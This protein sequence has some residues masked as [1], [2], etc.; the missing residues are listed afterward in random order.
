M[1]HD[2]NNEIS[3][4]MEEARS[5][6]KPISLSSLINKI[7]KAKINI[8]KIKWQ[9]KVKFRLSACTLVGLG[10]VGFYGGAHIFANLNKYES[11]ARKEQQRRYRQDVENQWK[12]SFYY[13][14]VLEELN[15]TC[16]E[17]APLLLQ[18]NDVYCQTSIPENNQTYY[19]NC[20][21]SNASHILESSCNQTFGSLTT[22]ESCA[23]TFDREFSGPFNDVFQIDCH[24]PSGA[25]IGGSFAAFLI[26]LL[27][28]FGCCVGAFS[29]W[30]LYSRK[31]PIDDLAPDTK[32]LLEEIQKDSHLIEF[33]T[34]LKKSTANEV[35]S[36]L[37]SLKTKVVEKNERNLRLM[38]FLAKFYE[39]ESNTGKQVK[40]TSI[41]PTDIVHLICYFAELTEISPNGYS[42]PLA[43]NKD[44]NLKSEMHSPDA[45]SSSNAYFV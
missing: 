23:T 6:N 39:R 22:F 21:S 33:E 35:I 29:T 32:D 4:P 31:D 5:D 18:I 1:Q 26:L 44:G 42:T 45:E 3:I 25:V 28:A 30:P 16:Q 11:R 2:E 43:S 9:K 12:T 24:R 14:D 10:A 20:F 7:D 40:D 41:L 19:G 8:N 36:E 38:T 34:N 15:K 37:N 13:S 27:L 17:L